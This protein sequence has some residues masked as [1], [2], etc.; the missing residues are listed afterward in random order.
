MENSASYKLV[1]YKQLKYALK[2]VQ[3]ILSEYNAKPMN[4]TL[5]GANST[6]KVYIGQ[7]KVQDQDRYIKRA[8][9][10]F[11]EEDSATLGPLNEFLGERLQVVS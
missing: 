7:I 8:N 6:K 5:I 9:I 4:T 10:L 11:V 2:G 1:Y 3:Y